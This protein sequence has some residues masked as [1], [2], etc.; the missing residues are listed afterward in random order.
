ME[1]H[2][3]HYNEKYGDFKTALKYKDGIAVVAFF[4]QSFGRKNNVDFNKI[5]NYIPSIQKPGSRVNI[6]SG[7]LKIL[8]F[9]QK[10]QCNQLINYR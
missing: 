9:N 8:D 7:I 5:S 3:V 1:A 2:L 4:I 10:I 6:D